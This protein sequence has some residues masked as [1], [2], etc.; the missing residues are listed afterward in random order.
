MHAQFEYI[1]D[2]QYEVKRL[3]KLV[4]SFRTGEKYTRMEKEFRKT[5]DSLK[6]EIR[7][8]KA[9][10]AAARAETVK[11]RRLWGQACEDLE[12][13]KDAQLARTERE[14]TKTKEA[15]YRAQGERDEALGK[16]REKNL[17]LYKVKTQLEEEKGKNLELTARVNR[18]YTNSSKPS[19]QSPAHGKIHNGR[20]KTGRKRGGQPGHAHHGRKRQEPDR[21]V[22]IP[23]PEEVVSSGEYRPTGKLIRRQVVI[24]HMT[25]EVVE[26][27]TPEYVSRK[28]GKKVHAAFPEGV[29]DDVNYDGTVR[30]AAY[31][32]NNHCC[33]SISRTGE[34]LKEVSKG[35]LCLS[36]GMVCGL[37]REFSEKTQ[38]ERDRIFLELL[39]SPYMHVDF[40]FGRVNGKQGAV[41]V[42]ASGDRVL[43]Q[44]REKKGH[45][46]VKG[47]P[48]EFYCG[49]LVHDHEATFQNYG[50]RHQECLVHVERHLRSSMENEPGL[51]WNRQMLEWIREAVHYR[52]SIPEGGEADPEKTEELVKRYGEILEKAESEYGYE[53]PEKYFMDGYNLYVRMSEDRESY[54]LFLKDLSIPPTNNAAEN[55]AR[56]YKRKNAQAMCF[57]SAEGQGYF[58]DGLSVMESMKAKGENLYEGVVERFSPAGGTVS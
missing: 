31:L 9:E 25:T 56:K 49:T 26:Y 3:E 54:L 51:E 8:L 1:T 36:D 28:T 24:L 39:A 21:T 14:L 22:E 12:K 20:E 50:S 57:R 48:A 38:E 43:Y 19:S 53:P 58:C 40:T 16:L 10:L 6:R 23:A 52:N 17:E 37:S 45:E 13:E 34:F 33:V 27:V 18:D 2:L 29:K 11:V 15:M 32:L 30:A 42:C 46:G 5:V 47:S 35:K 44:G 4:E 7:R 55:A 41:M